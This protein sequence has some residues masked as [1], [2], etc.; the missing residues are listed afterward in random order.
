[1]SPKPTFS[2]TPEIF[3]ELQCFQYKYDYVSSVGENKTHDFV[4][5]VKSLPFNLPP[6][7]DSPPWLTTFSHTP[8]HLKLP[9]VARK[10]HPPKLRYAP[11]THPLAK[12]EVK[13]RATKFTQRFTRLGALLFG[14]TGAYLIKRA[15]EWGCDE[16][17]CYFGKEACC[18]NL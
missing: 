10:L 13:Q 14:F 15:N 5:V 16:Q 18:C 4:S 8:I 6:Q 17:E 1:L 9:L 7:F 11:F 12:H 2:P 3:P